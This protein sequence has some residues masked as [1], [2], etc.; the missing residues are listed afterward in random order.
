KGRAGMFEATRWASSEAGR[1]VRTGLISVMCF[2]WRKS[3]IQ[4]MR[5]FYCCLV[6]IVVIDTEKKRLIEP[7]RPILC[8]EGLNGYIRRDHQREAAGRR[9]ARARRCAARRAHQPAQRTGG[10]RASARALRQ[11]HTGK[12]DRPSQNDDRS[13]KGR[14]SSSTRTADDNRKTGWRQ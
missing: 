11:G 7:D 6:C 12:K 13:T 9:S 1:G 10:D 3:L 14:S 8:F 4:S 5:A 2:P